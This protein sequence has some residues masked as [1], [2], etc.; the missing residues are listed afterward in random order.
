MEK[1]LSSF[2]KV[3]CFEYEL[4]SHTRNKSKS[5]KNVIFKKFE[6]PEG[7][8][9]DTGNIEQMTQNED[10]QTKPTTHHNKR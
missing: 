9:R 7:E 6:K 4:S 2:S 10:K 8:S 1:E 3:A 5:N